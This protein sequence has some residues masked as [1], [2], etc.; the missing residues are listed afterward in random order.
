MKIGLKDKELQLNEDVLNINNITSSKNEAI[1]KNNDQSSTKADENNIIF[2]EPIA[3]CSS[4][5]IGLVSIQ[6]SRNN[7]DRYFKLIE[8]K[9]DIPNTVSIYIKQIKSSDVDPDKTDINFFNK[10]QQAHIKS[11]KKKE[12]KPIV[13]NSY[14]NY[15]VESIKS[16]KNNVINAKL[17]FKKKRMTRKFDKE[18][19]PK[20][21][22]KSEKP[23]E[24]QFKR[25]STSYSISALSEKI[26]KIKNKLHKQRSIKEKEKEENIE[27]DIDNSN[28]DNRDLHKEKEKERDHTPNIIIYGSAS[29]SEN[30]DENNQDENKNEDDYFISKNLSNVSTGN[31]NII[32]NS[33]KIEQKIVKPRSKPSGNLMSKL[34]IKNIKNNKKAKMSRKFTQNNIF[35]KVKISS[36]KYSSANDNEKNREKDKKKF[37]A[38]KLLTTKNL[39]KDDKDKDKDK[40]KDSNKRHRNSVNRHMIS[41]KQ[42]HKFSLKKHSMQSSKQMKKMKTNLI[43]P[44]SE[45][46]LKLSKDPY[47]H[48]KSNKNLRHNEL[49]KSIIKKHSYNSNMHIPRIMMN[50]KTQENDTNDI[51]LVVNGNEEKIINY[52]NQQMIEDEKDY[53][54]DCLKVLAKLKKEEAPRCKQKVNFNFPPDQNQKKIALF[55]LDETLVHCINNGPGMNGDVVSVKLPTNKI[56]KVGLNIRNNWKIAFDLIKNHYHIVVYTASHPSYAD[57][58]LDYLDKENNYFKYRLYRS[59]CVQCDVDGFKFYVKDLDIL[60][61]YYNLKDIVIID[62]SILSFAYHLY[63]G[64][65]IIPFISQANDTELMFTAYYLVSIANYDDLSLENKKHLNLDNLLSMATMLNKMEDNEEEEVDDTDEGKGS[66]LEDTTIVETT[67]IKVESPVEQNTE[68]I[69]LNPNTENTNGDN[70]VKKHSMKR[71]RKTV[72]MTEDMKKNLTDLLKKKKDELEKIDEDK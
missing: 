24:N 51:H 57:A 45:M 72:K 52:T 14:S 56:V 59:H 3:Y 67:N 68:L 27:N 12:K 4:P 36:S 40:D 53:M 65:P 6:G 44:T 10:K 43:K 11:G 62:N 64:I 41:M 16:E 8:D 50:I 69:I 39:F 30:G 33:E 70:D 15:S 46:S 31:I 5:K 37:S 49:E 54:I 34:K 66:K 20:K 26:N 35:H 18:K 17:C 38:L 1:I 47:Y 61:K 71:I 22:D 55:D 28:S 48:K 42:Y 2:D 25:K 58:V 32:N 21:N 7:N 60:D 63:N 9:S 13:I 23:R 19:S 29:D